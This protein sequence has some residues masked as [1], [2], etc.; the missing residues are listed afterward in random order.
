MTTVIQNQLT[1]KRYHTVINKI[2]FKCI[3]RIRNT[4]LSKFALAVGGNVGGHFYRNIVVT[5]L[6]QCDDTDEF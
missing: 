1:C 2:I 5:R 6:L 3:I 4:K